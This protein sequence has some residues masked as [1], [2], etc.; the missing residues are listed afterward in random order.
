MADE[1]RLALAAGVREGVDAPGRAR[2]TAGTALALVAALFVAPAAAGAAKVKVEI[3]GVR[4]DVRDNVRA[5]LSLAQADD[6]SPDRVRQLH[7]QATADVERALQ[8]FGYYR[9]HVEAELREEGGGFVARYTV[10][11]GPL[12]R[13]SGVDLQLT[14]DGASDRGF[15]RAAR[16]FPLRRGSPLVHAS[17]EAGKQAL[18]D[19]AASHGYLDADFTTHEIRVDLAAYT[20]RIRLAF[21]TGP[22]YAF[23]EVTFDDAMVDERLLRGY[24]AFEPGEPFDLRKLLQTQDALSSTPYFKR[25]EVLP[26]EEHAVDRR[27]PIHVALVPARRERWSLGLGY[28][29]DTGPRATVGV[30]VRRVNRRGHRAETLANVSQVQQRFTGT[31]L[32]PKRAARTDFTTFSLGYDDLHSDT[33]QHRNGIVSFGLDRARGQW[34]EHFD[35]A[36]SREDFTVGP[37]RGTSKLLMPEASLS[38]LSADDVLYPLHGR[39]VRLQLRAANEAVLGTATFL[40]GIAEAKYVQRLFGP[41]R[42]LARVRLGYTRTPNFHELPSSLRFFAGGDQSVRGY[43]FQELTPR[44]SDGQPLGGDALVETSLE[45][46]ALLLQFRSFGRFGAAVFLDA[47]NALDRLEVSGK[48]RVGTGAGIR[49]L[50]PIG[51]VRADVAFAV[52]EPGRPIRFHFSLGPDL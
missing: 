44:S 24:L 51:L 17:Y 23:G 35:L 29:A 46:D 16:S 40:Q 34:R 33:A 3:D 31:Y 20:A 37:D 4:G 15:R 26:E 8:P 28:G 13:L 18:V 42:G 9:P 12:L 30:D 19:Y 38:L 1:R 5:L 41:V 10:D 2:A 7:A 32:V 36:W 22:R 39:K 47:G 6:P 52:D 25:V 21:Y 49:W 43:G 45:V 50:S 14:G 11:P 48:L 27:V